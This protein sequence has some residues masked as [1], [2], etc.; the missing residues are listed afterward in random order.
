MG[1]YVLGFLVRTETEDHAKTAADLLLKD[2]C[3]GG[4]GF[5]YGSTGRALKADSP[6]GKAVIEQIYGWMIEGYRENLANIREA[7]KHHSDT[8]IFSGECHAPEGT[9]A[10][11]ALPRLRYHMYSLGMYVGPAVRL[12]APDGNGIRTLAELDEALNHDDSVFIVTANAHSWLVRNWNHDG[13]FRFRK[14][15]IDSDSANALRNTEEIDRRMGMLT[16]QHIAP[17]IDYARKTATKLGS[18]HEIPHFDPCDGGINA[19]I[20]ILL[21]APGRKAVGSNFISRN[22]PDPSARNICDLLSE[23][24]IPRSATL[25]WNIVPWYVGTQSKIRAVRNS[26]IEVAMPFVREL[27]SLLPHLKAIV[28]VGRKAQSAKLR[29]APLTTGRFF[30]CPHPSLQALNRNP[31]HRRDIAKCFESVS[32]FIREGT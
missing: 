28:L 8:E 32:A 9:H 4:R 25:L 27:I 30:E 10:K 5:S 22:N 23:A 26:D 13:P 20:L 11:C 29:L 15:T 24:E 6:E 17:L 1:S 31:R 18:G 3:S 2:I 7:L 16:L 14:M 12:Y 21:E 19:Q